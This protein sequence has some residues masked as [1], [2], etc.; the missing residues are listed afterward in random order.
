MITDVAKALTAILISAGF[1][2]ERRYRQRK[3]L[4][5]FSTLRVTVWPGSL[6]SEEAGRGS[7]LRTYTF[8]VVYQQRLAAADE[9]AE[10]LELDAH[11]VRVDVLLTVLDSANLPP[12]AGA[13]ATGLTPYAGS[14]AP[15][16]AKN[17]EELRLFTFAVRLTLEEYVEVA[18]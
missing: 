1:P 16:S 14:G 9:A 11:T 5:E 10:I 15:W 12:L 6:E 4:E 17:L 8:D 3:K 18:P 13:E 7:R 2:A